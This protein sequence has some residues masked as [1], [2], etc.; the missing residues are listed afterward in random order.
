MQRQTRI[1]T[2]LRQRVRRVNLAL[3]KLQT[4]RPDTIEEI[5]NHHVWLE[6]KYKLDRAIERAKRLAA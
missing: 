1:E 2:V 5:E 6:E 4:A 3:Y